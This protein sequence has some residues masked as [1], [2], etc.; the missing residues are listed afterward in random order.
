MAFHGEP[1]EEKDAANGAHDQK[2]RPA[3]L[4]ASHTLVSAA[5]ARRRRRKKLLHV[6]GD[7]GTTA[8]F[9]GERPRD[10]RDGEI[11]CSPA[12]CWL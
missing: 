12:G 2:C 4:L 6:P 9:V 5:G 1:V 11:V 8:A 3:I 10:R 7:E